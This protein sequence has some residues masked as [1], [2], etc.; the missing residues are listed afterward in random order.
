MCGI[1]GF[2]GTENP[3]ALLQMRDALRHRGPDEASVYSDPEISLG[4]RR[5]S[6]IDLTT[7]QQPVYN[8]D[9]SILV[10]FN[11]EIYNHGELRA[12]LEHSGHRYASQ[13]D[14]E[15]IVHAYESYGP[16]CVERI[17]VM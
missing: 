6:I 12:L 9:R 11:G 5:L 16:A 13:S 7:G 2:V 14:T 17:H 4:H 3:D 8:E 10:I 1:C 15:A